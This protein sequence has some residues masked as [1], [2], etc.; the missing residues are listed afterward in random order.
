MDLSV[1]PTQLGYQ[2]FFI[3]TQFDNELGIDS[4]KETIITVTM[5]V[6]ACTLQISRI[7]NDYIP[8]FGRLA[9]HKLFHCNR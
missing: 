1:R 4:E 5:N 6:I 9:L 3:N 7:T 2:T 8:Y